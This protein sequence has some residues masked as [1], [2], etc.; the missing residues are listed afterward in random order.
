MGLV[1]SLEDVGACLGGD[2]KV[3]DDSAEVCD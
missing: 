1:V 3:R 2:E